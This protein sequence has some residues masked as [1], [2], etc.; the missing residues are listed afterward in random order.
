MII[1]SGGLKGGSGKTALATNLAVMRSLDGKD[2]L[3]IDADDQ[4]SSTSFSATR[5]REMKSAGYTIVQLTGAAVQTET[6]RLKPKYDDIIIDVGGRDTTSLRA[7]IVVA[8]AFIVPCP[9]RSVDIETLPDVAEVITDMKVANPNIKAYCFINRADSSGSDNE[10]AAKIIKDIPELKFIDMS[11]G[12][13]KA[14]G[15]AYALGQAVTELQGIY[16]DVKAA[17]EMKAL[18]K[19]IFNIK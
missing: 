17:K 3:L 15:N 12:S 14:F 6:V 11:L 5:N 9:P 2:V 4:G 19:F 1:I 18:Y 16:K 7:A 8:D 10:A 13:R